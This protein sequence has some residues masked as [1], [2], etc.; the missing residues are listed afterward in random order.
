[1]RQAIAGARLLWGSLEPRWRLVS[2]TMFLAWCNSSWVLG[3]QAYS[4][5]AQTRRSELV[6]ACGSAASTMALYIWAR[7]TIYPL[8]RENIADAE[9][10]RQSLE[11]LPAAP[12]QSSQIENSR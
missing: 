4:R 2:K 12:A 3:L 6:F 5:I 1:M 11:P 7:L 8:I 9:C 10:E